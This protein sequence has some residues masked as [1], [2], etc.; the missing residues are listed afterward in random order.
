MLIDAGFSDDQIRQMT[1]RNA[2]DLAG[3]AP[4]AN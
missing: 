3:L 1:A 2:A 4:A